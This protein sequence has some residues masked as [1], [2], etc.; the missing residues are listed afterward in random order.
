MPR[1][2]C[3]YSFGTVID[4]SML[5]DRLKTC[6]LVPSLVAGLLYDAS[7]LLPKVSAALESSKT[8][9]QGEALQLR[10]R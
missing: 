2:V 8:M 4:D 5:C 7:V 10:M 6:A 9:V 1:G 3:L